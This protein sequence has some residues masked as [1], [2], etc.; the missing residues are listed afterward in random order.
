MA[1]VFI[2][3]VFATVGAGLSFVAWCDERRISRLLDRDTHPTSY[4]NRSE[5]H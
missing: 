3:M 5:D 1:L 2:A 4:A